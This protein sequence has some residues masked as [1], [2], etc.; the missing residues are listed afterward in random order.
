[1]TYFVERLIDKLMENDLIS[2]KDDFNRAISEKVLAKL[3]SKKVELSKK[4][5]VNNDD[6]DDEDDEDNNLNEALPPHLQRHFD[7]KGKKIEG[8]WIKTKDGKRT[9]VPLKKQ[10]TKRSTSRDVTPKGYGPDEDVEENSAFMGKVAAAKKDGK[11]KFKLGDKE[12]PVTMKKS[13][14]EKI[15]DETVSSSSKDIYRFATGK[16]PS[17]KGK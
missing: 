14:A 5:I 7:D 2:A 17:G 9:W 8:K 6:D 1:M 13:T 15:L 12:F 16:K 3:E 11:K 4:M 10:K